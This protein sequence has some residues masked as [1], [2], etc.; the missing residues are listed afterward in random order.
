MIKQ[1]EHLK[2]TQKHY[3]LATRV[4][5]GLI[6][7]DC[8]QTSNWP[9]IRR[10][11][12]PGLI[13]EDCQISLIDVQGSQQQSETISILAQHDM[14]YCRYQA[15]TTGIETSALQLTT[16]PFSCAILYDDD[17]LLTILY[18]GDALR[19]ASPQT[20]GPKTYTR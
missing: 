3:Y 8:R 12:R 10:L 11:P 5:M 13:S 18:I 16:R 6:S 1:H 20:T 2:H 19:C 14:V 4:K 17:F 15:S 9:Y 7:E